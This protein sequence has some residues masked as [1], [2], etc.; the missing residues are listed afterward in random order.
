M[1]LSVKAWALKWDG[2]AASEDDIFRGS[3]LGSKDAKLQFNTSGGTRARTRS[4]RGLLVLMW[5]S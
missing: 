4:C 1:P 3:R 5:G 2:I